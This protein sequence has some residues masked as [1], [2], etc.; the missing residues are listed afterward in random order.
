L[1]KEKGLGKKTFKGLVK[2]G[3]PGINSFQFLGGKG[4]FLFVFFGNPG[5]KLS[6]SVGCNEDRNWT[7]GGTFFWKRI[8][9]LRNFPGFFWGGTHFLRLSSFP[10]WEILQGILQRGFISGGVFPKREEILLWRERFK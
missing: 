7:E 5:F 9:G 4:E 6:A 8:L 2:K 10:P 3:P 1:G